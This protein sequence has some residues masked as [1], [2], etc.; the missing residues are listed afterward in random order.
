MSAARAGA[1][2]RLAGLRRI[3]I[4]EI[5]YRKGHRYL[6]VVI[7]H[8]TGRIVWSGEGRRRETVAAFF[9]ALGHERARQLTHMSADGAQW[10]GDVVADHAPQAMRCLD[11]FHAVGWIT[12]AL[13]EV[14]RAVWNELRGGRGRSTPES[15]AKG[16]R[17]AL[18][19]NPERLNDKQKATLATIQ[20]TNRP[21]Y[22]AYLLK[23]Q[24]R[25]IF[26]VKGETGR[27]LLKAWLRWAARSKIPALVKV[28]QKVRRHLDE[29]HNT[30]DC[31]LSNVRSE[32]TNTH[33]RVL[34]RRAYGYK[35][36]Q[37]LIAMANLTR[38][39]LCPPLPGR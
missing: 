26:K 24:F 16:A 22:R 3:G 17:W 31:G 28:A 36:A 11:A 14:R 13:D 27:L 12:D 1:V 6:V 33:L 39:G 32:A 10:I 2:D 37:G 15:K 21:L 20:A 30:L 5:A 8:E 19:K 35:S 7:D 23:E 29:I 34:T 4:D 18:W 25:E 9:T 38:S